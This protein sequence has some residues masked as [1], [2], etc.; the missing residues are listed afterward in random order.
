[1]EGRYMQIVWSYDLTCTIIFVTKYDG[2]NIL[3]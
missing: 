2:H 1:V 3:M